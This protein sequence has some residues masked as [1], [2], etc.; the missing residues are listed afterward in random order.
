MSNPLERSFPEESPS[1]DPLSCP[2]PSQDPIFRAVLESLD[3]GVIVYDRQGH[4]LHCN[5]SAATILGVDP[6]VLTDQPLHS[7]HWHVTDSTG[8][9]LDISEYPASLCLE[10]GIPITDQIIGVTRE[11]GRKVWLSVSA[12]PVSLAPGAPHQ[13]AA[14]AFRDVTRKREIEI[15]LR[16][17]EQR[18]RTLIEH[19]P[20]VIAVLDAHSLRHMDVNRQAESFFMSSRQE[21]LERTPLDFSVSPQPDGHSASLAFRE[22]VHSALHGS[23][24]VFEWVFRRRTG[25]TLLCE[26]R[27]G[28]MPSHE[29]PLIHLSITD[30]T[31]R[32]R[33]QEH[34]RIMAE[35]TGQLIYDYDLRSGEIIWTGAITQV[36]GFSPEEM[37]RFN[38]DEWA[39]AIHP[40]DRPAALKD[41][42]KAIQHTG[43]YEVEY[44]FRRSDGSYIFVEDHGVVIRDELQNPA[45]MLGTM[46]D[47]S[48]RKQQQET[49]RHLEAQ[50]RHAQKMEAVGTLAGGVAHDFN[51]LLGA[52]MGYSDL[53]RLESQDNPR[54]QSHLTEVLRACE[55]ARDLVRQILTFSRRQL[56]NLRPV[57]LSICLKDSLRLLRATLPTTIRIDTQIEEPVFVHGD[58][59]Q[60]EQVI[61][62]LGTNAA[63]AIGSRPGKIVCTLRT[64]TLSN[65]NPLSQFPAFPNG[66]YALIE[67]EDNGCGMDQETLK[68]IFEPFFTTKE[69]GQGTGLGLSV[70]HGIITDHRGGISAISTPGQGTKFTILLPVISQAPAD[71]TQS[72]KL[73]RGSGQRILIVDDDPDLCHASGKIVEMLGYQAE[74]SCDPALALHRIRSGQSRP[75]LV[76]LD[77][78][79]PHMT[80]TELAAEIQKIHPHLPMVMITGYEGDATR[81]EAMR[82][83]IRKICTKPLRSH[84]LAGVLAELLHPM[85]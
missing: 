9:R 55:R 26:V 18:Y 28:L 76:I 4:A 33:H 8:R 53:A 59:V 58:P 73:Q 29:P 5:E 43:I 71:T 6:S 63:Q 41:L 49:Q 56:P 34:F 68:R 80:G 52:I 1:P 48:A 39:N 81:E 65:N 78:A 74:T 35:Q 38:I 22:H 50:L 61:I 12:R 11:D 47:I 45:F 13:L 14:V 69:P 10:K 51:N 54:A 19:S 20:D 62:N 64:V 42:E 27:M 67:M 36:T 25:E 66:P 24:E 30:I 83:G 40:E 31:Q 7:P 57:N 77:L 17:S 82:S 84:E 16:L 44:R 79:M 46:S 23:R 70:V 72:T 3:T 2:D 60:L 75:D 32:R 85:E 15:A 21:L 37:A